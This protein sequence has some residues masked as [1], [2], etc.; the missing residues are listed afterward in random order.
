MW[1]GGRTDMT[2]LIDAF[3]HFAK[4]SKHAAHYAYNVIKLHLPSNQKAAMKIG[5]YNYDHD[6]NNNHKLVNSRY[7]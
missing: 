2:K 3:Y 5:C 7:I 1:A 4:A 6:N